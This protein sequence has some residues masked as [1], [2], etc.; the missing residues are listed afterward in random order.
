MWITFAIAASF[1]V[2]MVAMAY[3]G[4]ERQ[5]EAMDRADAALP[6]GPLAG[7]PGC[8][9]LCRAPLRRAVSSDQVVFELEHRIDAELREIARAFHSAPESFGRTFNA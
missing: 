4:M 6:T 8:C 1:V 9:E 3:F 2:A 5:G 7:E